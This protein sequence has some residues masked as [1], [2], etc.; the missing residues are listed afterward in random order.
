M[1]TQLDIAVRRSPFPVPGLVK[2]SL[3]R[4]TPLLIIFKMYCIVKNTVKKS[5][6]T[7]VYMCSLVYVY[8]CQSYFFFVF[9]SII[10]CINIKFNKIQ[11]KP[12][13]TNKILTVFLK[14]NFNTELP[15]VI[16]S[17]ALYASMSRHYKAIKESHCFLV[18][19]I[20]FG[21]NIS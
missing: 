20:A 9:S 2:T 15:Y 5:I 21:F 8:F 1:L 3:S 13:K 6:V 12:E 18:S 14:R 4:E 16:T 17:L 10:I 19:K 11:Q 7:L